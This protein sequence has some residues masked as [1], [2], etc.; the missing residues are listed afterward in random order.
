MYIGVNDRIKDW[1][2]S[3]DWAEEKFFVRHCQCW[4][5]KKKSYITSTNYFTMNTDVNNAW[6]KERL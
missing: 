4:P 2:L 1:W 6:L 3:I 5:K